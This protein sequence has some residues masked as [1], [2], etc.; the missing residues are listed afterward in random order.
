M[1]VANVSYA[2]NKDLNAPCQLLNLKEVLKSI[3]FKK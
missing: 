3:K 2:I 1:M